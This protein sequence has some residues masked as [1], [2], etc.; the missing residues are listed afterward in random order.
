M[1]DPIQ[2][3]TTKSV[4]AKSNVYLNLMMFGLLIIALANLYMTVKS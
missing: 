4:E 2:T 1:K 3:K